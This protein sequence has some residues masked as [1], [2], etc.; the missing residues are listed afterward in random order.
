MS[1]GPVRVKIESRGRLM[2]KPQIIVSMNASAVSH[3]RLS[4]LGRLEILDTGE[5]RWV[6][7]GADGGGRPLLTLVIDPNL[8][9]KAQVTPAGAFLLADGWTISVGSVERANR[10]KE[11]VRNI[12]F[13]RV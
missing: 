10:L 11:S 6:L 9:D 3:T 1:D 12:A 13:A 7:R 4:T 5:V 2:S 8:I